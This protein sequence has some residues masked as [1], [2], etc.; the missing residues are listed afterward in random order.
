MTEKT[1]KDRYKRKNFISLC[2]NDEE[3]KDVETIAERLNTTRAAAIREI[4]VLNS[5][6]IKAKIKK[7]DN[8]ELLF[9]LSNISNNINQVAKKINSNLN[10]FLSS[11]NSDVFIELM[12]NI[13]KDIEALK[14]DT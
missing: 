8:S 7:N 6:Q 13:T 12:E 4:L 5:R 2:L 11:D 1:Y 10:Y 9:L 14:N 3:L